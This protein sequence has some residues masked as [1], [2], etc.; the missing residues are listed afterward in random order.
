M[1]GGFGNPFDV[2]T[3]SGQPLASD[4]TADIRRGLQRSGYQVTPVTVM[5][6][7]RPEY[8]IG[9]LAKTG[10]QRLLL[11]Q[12]DAWKSDTFSGTQLFYGLRMQVYDPQGLLLARAATSGR[13]NVG[14]NFIDPAGHAETSLPRILALK[15]EL[16]LNDRSIARA[17]KVAAPP[18][19][20]TPTP[21][22]PAAEPT[23]TPAPDS[24]S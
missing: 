1:R 7:S 12:I 3:A 20:E 14:A 21:E 5:A 8:A 13:D 4:F 15:L 16:L 18:P 24:D 17:L 2:T 6:G 10:A 22:P 9:R 11:V 19:A 23:V